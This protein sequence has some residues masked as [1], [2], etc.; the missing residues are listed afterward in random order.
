MTVTVELTYDLAQLL[1]T[2]R[3]ELADA[4]TVAEALDQV[5]GRFGDRGADFDRLS[6]GTALAVN[7]VLIIHRQHLGSALEPGDRLSFLKPASGG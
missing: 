3:L 2:Q 5:R 6:R 1:G 7:G 4:A